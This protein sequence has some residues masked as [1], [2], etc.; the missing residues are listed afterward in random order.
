MRLFLRSSVDI[1]TGPFLLAFNHLL[2]LP[3]CLY[4]RLSEVF[5]LAERIMHC[6][7]AFLEIYEL[8]YEKMVQPLDY[9]S[10]LT[11]HLVM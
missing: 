7:F 4:V 3:T 11:M 2:L 6:S 8:H 10:A 5:M 1:R 9:V